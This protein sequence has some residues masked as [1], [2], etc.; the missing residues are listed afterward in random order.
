MRLTFLYKKINDSKLNSNVSCMLLF[1]HLSV[2]V[3][4]FLP[5]AAISLVAFQVSS[6]KTSK[7]IGLKFD[8]FM[9]LPL[10]LARVQKLCNNTKDS[11]YE[12]GWRGKRLG[13][14]SNEWHAILMNDKRQR[15]QL[16]AVTCVQ[17]NGSTWTNDEIRYLAA[18][19]TWHSCLL[20]LKLTVA[21]AVAVA[22]QIVEP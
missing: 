17:I 10:C 5:P 15:C 21:V 18:W 12:E 19:P 16:A 11:P 9:V 6:V 4:C 1:S 14:V 22:T 13:T 20:L 8:E 3:S 2:S 7:Q